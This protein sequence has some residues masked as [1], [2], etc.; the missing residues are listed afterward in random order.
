MTS[1]IETGKDIMAQIARGT[2]ALAYVAEMAEHVADYDAAKK[3]ADERYADAVNSAAFT[4][5][6]RMGNA[7]RR[8]NDA[9]DQI[10][11]SHDDDNDDDDD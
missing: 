4:M 2:V 3:I 10:A 8:A 11:G 6:A 9:L 1:S 5:V 7:T